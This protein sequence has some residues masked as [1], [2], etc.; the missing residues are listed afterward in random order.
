MAGESGFSGGFGGGIA[1]VV[2]VLAEH[3][4][5]KRQRK[6]LKHRDERVAEFIASQTART[7][8]YRVERP[9]VSLPRTAA[10]MGLASGFAPLPSPAATSAPTPAPTPSP[11]P[12]PAPTQPSDTWSQV[13]QGISQARVGEAIEKGLEWAQLIAILR[14]LFQKP[15]RIRYPDFL[16]GGYDVPYNFSAV[17]GSYGGSDGGFLGGLASLGGSVAS[18]IN[19]IRSP[20]AM[21]GGG[22]GF[23]PTA[24]A[25][26][27]SRVA[28]YVIGGAA[29][30]IGE[31]IADYFQGNGGACPTKPFTSGGS[32][33]RA[34]TF[35]T[36]NP[37][38][39]KATWFKP[40]GR[41]IL[42]SGDLSACRRVRKVAGKARRRV[43]GR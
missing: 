17:P 36:A 25:G 1:G 8:A 6:F 20:Q 37:V 7:Q 2:G 33:A 41:P 28:P 35:V 29:G 18:V 10:L 27:L 19:A 34:T 4:G 31:T 43:G 22:L 32:S 12:T 13:L 30:Y 42:W 40:A 26:A 16:L 3:F 24:A 38:T 39:G 5:G 21:P 15:K 23:A 9:D 11:Q 14:Q